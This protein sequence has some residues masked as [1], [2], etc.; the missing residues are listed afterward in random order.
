MTNMYSLCLAIAV[1]LI[2]TSDALPSVNMHSG[3]A[4]CVWDGTGCYDDGCDVEQRGLN[5]EKFEQQDSCEGEM[6]TNSRCRWSMGDVVEVAANAY[7]PNEDIIE[8]DIDGLCVWDGTGCYDDG[9]DPEARGLNCKKFEQQTACEG[10]SGKENR[11]RW[12]SEESSSLLFGVIDFDFAMPNPLE[13][14]WDVILV[15][16]VLFVFTAWIGYNAV[17]WCQRPKEFE[18]EPIYEVEM[19]RV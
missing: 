12:S 2:F 11:C 7:D 17:R 5:C 6:G 1:S 10:D 3:V 19:L 18:Y 13:M 16:A 4:S 15:A 8:A 9:C 14:T